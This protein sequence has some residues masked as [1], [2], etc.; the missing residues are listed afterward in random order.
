MHSTCKPLRNLRYWCR[1][2]TIFDKNQAVKYFS[3]YKNK[4]M[5]TP[6]FCEGNIQIYGNCEKGYEPVKDAFI[7]NFVSGQELNASLCVYVKENCVIDL[8]GTSNK[9]TTYNAECLQVISN[10]D[11]N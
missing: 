7:Q 9:D 3:Y 10:D 11:C 6:L 5:E 4:S 1:H 2:L 8:Y